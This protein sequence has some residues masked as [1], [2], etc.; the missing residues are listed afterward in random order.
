SELQGTGAR[1]GQPPLRRGREGD[2]QRGRELELAPTDLLRLADDRVARVAQQLLDLVRRG[3]RILLENERCGARD[4]RRRFGRAAAPEV[5]GV[6][7]TLGMV[8]VDGGAGH[9]QALE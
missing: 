4:D 5:A 1:C 7:Q 6:D 9:A 2:R 8:E 3:V